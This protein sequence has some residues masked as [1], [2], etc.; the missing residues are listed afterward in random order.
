[1]ALYAT[2]ENSILPGVKKRDASVGYLHDTA[3]HS[4]AE[5][6]LALLETL[7]FWHTETVQG[8][9]V[10]PSLLGFP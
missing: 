3:S 9:P 2:R 6:V 10:E 1:V 5:P 7:G 4:V 8:E